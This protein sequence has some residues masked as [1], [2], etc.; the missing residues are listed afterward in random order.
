MGID[1]GRREV[2]VP[3]HALHGAKIRAPLEQVCRERMAQHMGRDA[4]RCNSRNACNFPDA[5]EEILPG[6]RPTPS[7]E[8]DRIAIG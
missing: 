6:H 8:K 1:F 2:R 7:R 4:L 3:E 5:K